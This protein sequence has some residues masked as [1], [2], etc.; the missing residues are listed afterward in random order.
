MSNSEDYFGAAHKFVDELT[1]NDFNSEVPWELKDQKC[2]L[3]LFYAPWCGFCKAVK[4]NWESAA[5][6]TGF[7][8]Y[9]AFNCEKNKAWCLKI[10]EENPDFIKSYP[11][12]VVY[13]K[14][15]PIKN[16]E[17]ERDPPSLISL[18]M[19]SCTTNP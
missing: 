5:K 6:K 13:K 19:K 10:K 15:K 8:D 11:T 12:I 3:V 14:G 9:M 7:C 4:G 18:C 2:G 1:P 16:Y 17:G